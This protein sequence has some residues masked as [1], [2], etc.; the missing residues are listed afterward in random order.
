M[1]CFTY[2]YPYA[3]VFVEMNVCVCVCAHAYIHAMEQTAGMLNLILKLMLQNQIWAEFNDIVSYL[4]ELHF[5]L[6]Y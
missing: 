6:A 2:L 4:G 3:V 1:I 5:S